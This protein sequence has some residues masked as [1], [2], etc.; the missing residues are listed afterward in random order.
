MQSIVI[1][2]RC[3]ESG[4]RLRVIFARPQ[5]D[6]PYRV[7][8]IKSGSGVSTGVPPSDVPALTAGTPSANTIHVSVTNQAL[9]ARQ[10][11]WIGFRCPHC[12]GRS[13]QSVI[14]CGRCGELVCGSTY[15]VLDG[16]R[17]D[18]SCG[19]CGNKVRGFAGG[20]IDSFDAKPVGP[21]PSQSPALPAGKGLLGAA[22]RMLP[23]GKE[24]T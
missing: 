20:T 4:K 2:M 22:K 24:K 13:T 16:G 8:E 11:N 5:A 21:L 10:V 15:H 1:P 14:R 17:Y 12:D 18:F 3:S 19:A 23:R 7:R 9:D 6:M